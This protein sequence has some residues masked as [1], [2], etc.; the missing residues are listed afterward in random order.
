MF[1]GVFE[2]RMTPPVLTLI[3]S[4]FGAHGGPQ[5]RRGWAIKFHTHLPLPWDRNAAINLG[6]GR[7][8]PACG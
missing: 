4:G 5:P 8:A 2:G 3:G 6:P 7:P 1:P